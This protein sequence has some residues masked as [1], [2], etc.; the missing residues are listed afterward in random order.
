M[1]STEFIE[2]LA[3]ELDCEVS[4]IENAISSFVLKSS[5]P[6]SK[7]KPVEPSRKKIPPKEKPSKPTSDDSDND[8]SDKSEDDKKHTCDRIPRGKSE[9]CGKNAKNKLEEDGVVNWYC[10]TE[11]S[12]C[13]K[14]ILLGQKRQTKAGAS[15]P[16]PPPSKKDGP[17]KKD[18]PGKKE[19]PG[20]KAPPAK[21]DAVSKKKE[22]DVKAASLISKVAKNKALNIK[23]IKVKGELL[24][25]DEKNRLLFNK[26]SNKAYGVLNKDGV[27]IEKLTKENIRFLEANGIQ[28]VTNKKSVDTDDE[29]GDLQNKKEG[30]LEIRR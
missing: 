16:K 22:S 30:E 4:E 27:T 19:A 1:L 12:G 17:A 15:K 7:I 28:F 20:K 3:S 2:H 11:N 29:K 25:M 26:D 24:W 23:K 21:K 18:A 13:Y 14:S 5:N 10:G 6:K 8:D 9:S